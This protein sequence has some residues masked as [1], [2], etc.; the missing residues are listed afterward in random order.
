MLLFRNRLPLINKINDNREG[1]IVI[2]GHKIRS[3]LIY[4]ILHLPL[5]A[6]AHISQDLHVRLPMT[7]VVIV[8]MSSACRPDILRLLRIHPPTDPC[9]YPLTVAKTSDTLL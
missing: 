3:Q 1:V 4:Y 9:G 6:V 8:L 2:L 5:S 7:T